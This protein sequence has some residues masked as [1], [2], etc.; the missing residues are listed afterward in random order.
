MNARLLLCA[1]LA[2]ATACR[3][4][5]DVQPNPSSLAEEVVGTYRTNVY[6]DPACVATPTEQMPYAELKRESDSTV[7]LAYTSLYPDKA[8]KRIPN[9]LLSRQ[10]EAI[11]LYIAGSSAGTLATDRVFVNNG[12]EKQGKLLR[13]TLPGDSPNARAPIFIGLKQ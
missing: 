1:L 3:Q 7:T 6:L 10:P 4:E 2:T 8:I 9:V 5:G 13:L 11:H 12:M